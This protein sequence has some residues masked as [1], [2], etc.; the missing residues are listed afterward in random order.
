[1]PNKRINNTILKQFHS[2]NIREPTRYYQPMLDKVFNKDP[3]DIGRGI[4]IG[5]LKGFNTSHNTDQHPKLR[6]PTPDITEVNDKKQPMG[7]SSL[8][9]KKPHFV[10]GQGG[11]ER[12][13]AEHITQN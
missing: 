8:H 7:H 11:Q 2:K 13:D 10:F 3:K 5:D 1:M 6:P 9:E 12:A 4:K